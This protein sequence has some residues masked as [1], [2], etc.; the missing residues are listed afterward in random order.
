MQLQFY[1]NEKRLYL[2]HFKQ[3]SFATSFAKASEV[4]EGYGG[5]RSSF[6]T[7][8]AKASEVKEGYGGRSGV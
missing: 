7:S 2:R 6:A 5:R 1:I 4:K 3:S 8:F